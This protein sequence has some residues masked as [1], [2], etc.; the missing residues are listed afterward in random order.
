LPKLWTDSVEAH[1]RL[2]HDAVIDAAAALVREQGIRAI[3]MSH[4]AEK[5]D[6]GRATLYKY[7]PDVDAIL[8]AWHERQIGAHMHELQRIGARGRD[9]LASLR[10]VL[11]RYALIQYEH[12][13]AED[14]AQL[15]RGQHVARA[16]QHLY[17]FIA[18]LIVGAA[19]SGQVRKDIPA[20]ELASYA[21]HALGAARTLTSKAAVHRLVAM[22]MASLQSRGVPA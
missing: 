19:D 15:H 1:R 4:I 14:V 12:D 5:A 17:D 18:S 16:Q 2:V 13:G 7:F 3:T 10:S 21:I 8:A 20:G 6:I 22:T 9:P 11:E